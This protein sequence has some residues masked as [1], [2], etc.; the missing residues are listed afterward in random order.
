MKKEE[1]TLK[2]TKAENYLH[3]NILEIDIKNNKKM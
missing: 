3:K 2:N 1:I